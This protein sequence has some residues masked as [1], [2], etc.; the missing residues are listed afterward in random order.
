[1]PL[2]LDN[3]TVIQQINF[4]EWAHH[5]LQVHPEMT[6]LK[7]R[8]LFERTS[9][10]SRRR[11]NATKPTRRTGIR[12]YGRNYRLSRFASGGAIDLKA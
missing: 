4:V 9:N 5:D 3:A 6:M 8:D 10:E 11:T 1:M 2:P 7:A 12:L